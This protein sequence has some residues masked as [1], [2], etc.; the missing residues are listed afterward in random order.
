MFL[1]SESN[2]RSDAYGGPIHN[3]ARFLLEIIS[4]IH[5][6]IDDQSFSVSVKFYTTD[7]LKGMHVMC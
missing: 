1:S 5:K 3:R 6:R 7:F 2:T 4:A